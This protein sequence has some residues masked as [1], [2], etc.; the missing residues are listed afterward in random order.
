[1]NRRLNK[2]TN[3]Q[4]RQATIILKKT[5]IEP[6]SKPNQPKHQIKSN[7]TEIPFSNSI[8]IINKKEDYKWTIL[9]R[10]KYLAKM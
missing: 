3:L 6:I 4:S 5:L 8:I 10:V 2:G 7:L 9:K 1:M